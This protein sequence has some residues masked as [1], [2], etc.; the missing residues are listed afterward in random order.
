MTE[1]SL[2]ALAGHN[3]D[4][5]LRLTVLLDR[6]RREGLAGLRAAVEDHLNG[7]DGILPIAEVADDLIEAVLT[8]SERQNRPAAARRAWEDFDQAEAAGEQE[9]ENR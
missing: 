6:Y 4:A 7:E 8:L 5:Q 1:Q 2:S 9:R 3:R